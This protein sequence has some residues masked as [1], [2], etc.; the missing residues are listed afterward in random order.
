MS[1]NRI[2]ACIGAGRMGRGIAHAV[3]Y[4][5]HQVHLLD[6]KARDEAAFAQFQRETLG[7][8]RSTLNSLAKLGAFE[9]DAVAQI[10]AR[11]AVHP[12]KESRKFWS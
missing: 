2:T 1:Q 3:A 12:L 11:V 7:E 10:L 8:V 4:A 6:A 5:G 9:E